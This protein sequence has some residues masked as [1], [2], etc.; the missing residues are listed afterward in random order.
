MIKSMSPQN[1]HEEN[2]EIKIP[3]K[4]IRLTFLVILVNVFVHEIINDDC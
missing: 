2:L 3:I 1:K 4:K